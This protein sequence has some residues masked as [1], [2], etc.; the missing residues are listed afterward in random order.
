MGMILG[1]DARDP[2]TYFWGDVCRSHIEN[3]L[4]S[5]YIAEFWN[6]ITNGTFIILACL[7]AYTTIKYRHSKRMLLC[8]IAMMFVGVGSLWFHATLKYTTQLLDELPML[9]LTGL[10]LYATIEVKRGIKYGI[11]VPIAIATCL[12]LFSVV[13]IQ[14]LQS[15]VFHQVIFASTVL[16][17]FINAANRKMQLLLSEASQKIL[18]RAVTRGCVGM[19]GGFFVWNLDNIFC[20]QLRTY[21]SYV[22]APWDAVLQLHGWWHI[23]TAYGCYCLIL[24]IHFIRIAW[25]GHD[26]LFT[27]KFHLGLVPQITLIT[28]KKTN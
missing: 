28:P 9:Y 27:V 12:V 16:V 5:E 18:R 19:L 2:T 24:W 14:W 23:L 25:L 22:G 11:K 10:A 26:H 4:V 17:T 21:R 1:D 15:P 20:H 7:G 6:S 8:Y 3:Y 13:Y